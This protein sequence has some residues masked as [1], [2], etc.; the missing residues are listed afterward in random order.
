V[1]PVATRLIRFVAVLLLLCESWLGTP[2][3]A[4]QHGK[5]FLWKVSGHGQSAYLLGSI[6]F[7]NQDLYPFDA[8]INEAFA[9]SDV[10][11][12][13]ANILAVDPLE[14][15]RL[16]LAKGM[17]PDLENNLK[18]HISAGTWQLLSEKASRYGLPM[19]FLQQQKPW[20]AAITLST[21][22]FKQAGY[23]EDLG[24]DYYF[25]QQAQEGGKPIVDLET[26]EFQLNLFEQF[27][28]QEQEAFLLQTLQEIDLGKEYM[29]E[30]AVAWKTGDSTTIDKLVND[31]IEQ[32]PQT[33]RI[34]KLLLVDR[35]T[36]ML[37]KIEA[38]MQQGQTPFVCVGAGHMVG[39]D[40]LVALLKAKGYQVG[41]L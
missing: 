18:T 33:A 19:E 22:A 3:F 26:F 16:T 32:N 40:G 9:S 34:Y 6:H 15:A 39:P 38:M 25:L 7:G 11:A 17:Y 31:T 10:L 2:A 5:H 24:I 13:E 30:L 12:V 28:A 21:M 35:N 27:S 8:V 1:H 23:Q 14:V 37:A 4:E 20:L 41:Q 29:D 36:A